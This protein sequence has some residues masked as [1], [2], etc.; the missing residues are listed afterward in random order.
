MFIEEAD[1]LKELPPYLFAEID[2]MIIEKKAKGENVISLGIGDPDIQTPNEI[3]VE[4]GRQAKNPENHRYPSSY[5]LMLFKE[6]VANY[7]KK[8]FNVQ[9]DPESEIITLWGS[10]EGIA[11]I[12]YS[13]VN[14]GDVVLIP[15][16]GYLVYKIGTLFSGGISHAMPLLE[17]NNFLIDLNRIDKKISKRAKIMHL[18]YPNNPTSA[19][20]NLDFF[21][22]VADF[23]ARFNILVCH[24][25]AYSEVYFDENSKPAS[26]LNASGSKKVGIEF[27]SLSKTFNMTG[28]RIG[29]AVGNKKIIES[30]GKYKTNVDSGIFNAV[31]YAGAMALRDYSRHVQ[32]NISIYRKRR[33]LVYNAFNK[34]GLE[35]YKSNSTIYIWVK[36]PKGYN[37][38]S[39]TEILLNNAGVVVTPGNAFGEYGEGYIRISITLP[40]SSL[41]EALERIKKVL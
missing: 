19:C 16:P 22:E 27:N 2:K 10:K 6:A 20:S 18:N 29:Y 26:F 14:P 39:F 7:Y 36:V 15:D 23:A 41:E 1:R 25:N 4:L 38:R 21:N 40:D 33:E 3:I 30:L 5:G 11:N 13:F 24:D 28:W 8:R 9:L 34:I 37:S 31:Q 35:Y 12:A 32:H 17:K